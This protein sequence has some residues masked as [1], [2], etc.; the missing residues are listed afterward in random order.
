MDEFDR[1]MSRQR[2]LWRAKRKGQKPTSLWDWGHWG[3]GNTQEHHIA[4]RKFTDDV[5]T[6]PRAMHPELTRRQME[7]H[8]PEGRD[9]DSPVEQEGRVHIGLSDLH[10]A[11]SDGH[12]LIAERM[13]E[14]VGRGER[15]LKAVHIPEGLLGWLTRIAHDVSQAADRGVRRSDKG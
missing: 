10:A 7:E 6:V 1:F 4:R 8:P 3:D 5:I 11:L 9:P 2:A 12:R 13:L 14:A 15:D